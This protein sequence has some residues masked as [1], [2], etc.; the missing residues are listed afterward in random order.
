MCFLLVTFP[1]LI[2][3]QARDGVISVSVKDQFG[4]AV[5]GAEV[6]VTSVDKQKFAQNTLTDS[7]GNVRISRLPQGRY[8][9]TV[10]AP[11]FE[12]YKHDPFEHRGHET[13]I[14]EIVLNVASIESNVDVNNETISGSENTGFTVTLNE[15]V[16]ANLPDDQEELER[17]I[18]RLGEAV[19]G[20]E[21]PISVNGVEGGQI[22]PKAAIQQIRVNQSV[23]SAQYENPFGGG[24]EIFTRSGVDKYQTSVGFTF[25]DSR[26]NASDPFIGQRLPFQMRNYFASFSGPLFGKK[27]NFF[28][29]G[30]HT[31]S[32]SSSAINATVLDAGLQ[33]VAFKESLPTPTRNSGFNIV[34]NA[35]PTP[36][37]KLYFNYSLSLGESKNQNT[38]GFSLPSRANDTNTKF[39]YF[40]FSDTFLINPNIVNQTRFM[41]YFTDN[42]SFGG[43]DEPAVNVLEAFFGGGSQSNSSMGA[44]RFNVSNDTTWQMKR[45]TLGFGVRLGGERSSQTSMNNFGGTYTFSGRTAP[46]L[47]TNHQPVLDENGEVV[48]TQI[49]SLESY[50]RTL[51]FQDMGYS[52]QQI[53]ELGGG[54]N[55]FTISGGDPRLNASQY[56]FGIYV[57]NSFKVSETVAASFGLRYEN[58]TNIN[59]SANFAPR[60]GLIWAPKAKEKQSLLTTFPRVSIG[61]G[62]FFSRFALNN[63]VNVRQASDQ[64]RSQY[65]VIETEVLDSYPNVPTI[66]TLE[67]FALPQTQRFIAD[68]F[69]T[70]YQ[71]LLN[72]T[73]SKQMPKK[74]SITFTFSDG[75]VF[76]QSITRNINAPLAGTFD[77]MD[78]PAAVRPFGNVGNMFETSSIASSRTTR[79]SVSLGFPQSQKLFANL[80][81]SYGTS[82]DNAV[83]SSGSPYD[84]YDFSS[85]FGPTSFDGVHN[86]GGFF[87]LNLPHRINIGGDMSISSGRRFNI[88]TGRDTNGDGAYMERPAFAADLNKPGLVTT[89]YGVLDPNP[90][91]GDRIIPRNLAR[92][93]ASFMFNSSIS[94]SFAFN[95]AADK[96]TP[97]KQTLNFSLRVNNVFN[98]INKGTPVGNMTSPNFLQYLSGFSDGGILFING[99][100]QHTFAGRSMNLYVGF[101]F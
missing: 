22:P 5:A 52:G 37:H 48:M 11:G 63:T 30:R 4:G 76:R 68:G 69:E 20:E 61:Y 71:S 73:V 82:S 38:G 72:I 58:Q 101:S 55:Q 14:V 54:P 45:Y 31:D 79:Y 85:E 39:H 15:N 2:S 35:D 100:Q 99:A 50:R 60:F 97:P 96:K 93:P 25:A 23:F 12:E 3:A 78:P 43:S 90:G 36:K 8:I 59:N 17:A 41:A 66:E 88:T 26:L 47:D 29:S 89:P 65:L 80:R 81:Y 75:K 27:A 1:A 70:P 42:E 83:G 33:P 13:K 19:T 62:L 28:M 51:L 67:Q 9:I 92:G 10:V 16:I 86:A 21:L 53:R 6:S 24:I 32:D 94:K 87:F 74:F 46:M 91:P 40:Q 7:G 34:V 18:R 49:S 98:I 84:P 64:N 95:Q 57:Q 77:P 44:S 56:D